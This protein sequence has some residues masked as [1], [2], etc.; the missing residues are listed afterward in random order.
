MGARSQYGHGAS[1]GPLWDERGGHSDHLSGRLP[2]APACG[3][4]VGVERLDLLA[5]PPRLGEAV[6]A[7]DDANPYFIRV[8]VPRSR[9]AMQRVDTDQ[10]EAR[11]RRA[12]AGQRQTFAHD[13][14]RE[15]C[16][17]DSVRTR[18]GDLAFADIAVDI[19]DR[20][21]EQ[22]SLRPALA[23]GHAHAVQPDLLDSDSREI[24]DHVGW[25]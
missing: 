4:P 22:A 5:D 11:L 1:H 10:V 16:T 13:V 25:R 14:K 12:H 23:A 15:S 21:L 3:G 8:A 18:I 24:G 2:R 7:A 17:G 19:A 6:G 20:R 9:L